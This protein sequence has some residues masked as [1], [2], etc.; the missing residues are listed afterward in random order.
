M[1]STTISHPRTFHVEILFTRETPANTFWRERN[2]SPVAQVLHPETKNAA[3]EH[4]RPLARNRTK[5]ILR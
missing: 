1:I 5:Q 4:R 2:L 3:V